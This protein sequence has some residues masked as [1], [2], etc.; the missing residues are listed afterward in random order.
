M[1]S[2]SA[3][4]SMSE[5]PRAYR[6]RVSAPHAPTRAMR[7][8]T[9][10]H[11]LV[12]GGDMPTAPGESLTPSEMAHAESIAAAVMAHPLAM[13]YLRGARYEVPLEWTLSGVECRT[14]GIDILHPDR[15]G[16]LK[17][18]GVSPGRFIRHCE[19]MLYHAQIAW[20]DMA[21]DAI[22][23]AP[24][25]RPPFLLCVQSRIP[26]DVVVLELEPETLE[27]GRQHCMAW[28]EQY[29]GCRASDTWPG[30]SQCPIPWSLWSAQ[31]E[32]DSSEETESE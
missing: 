21:L 6:A 9:G 27:R 22:G 14:L 31:F 7:I 4:K 23:Y 28:I 29:K 13:E 11:R 16:D 2:Y 8:G 3:L 25:T 12:L 1:L 10:V 18:L 17:V 32:L 20:Y 19:S 24:R 26:Y 15:H 5:S 30:Y